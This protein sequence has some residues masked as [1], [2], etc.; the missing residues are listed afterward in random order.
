LAA[1]GTSGGTTPPQN[2]DGGGS[3]LAQDPLGRQCSS[4]SSPTQGCTTGSSTN[5]ERTLIPTPDR[6]EGEIVTA[7]DPLGSGV[8]YAVTIESKVVNEPTSITGTCIAGK[9]I[10]L[11]KFADS[12]TG[13]P[14][15]AEMPGLASIP[16]TDDEW[17]TDPWIGVG[18]D[19]TLYLTFLRNKNMSAGTC[20]PGLDTTDTTVEL[21]SAAAGGQLQPALPTPTSSMYPA[22]SPTI[23]NTTQ[24][25]DRPK[26]AASLTQPGLVYVTAAADQPTTTQGLVLQDFIAAFQPNAATGFYDQKAVLDLGTTAQ[27]LPLLATD[28]LGNLNAIFADTVLSNVPLTDATVRQYAFDPT[29]G[30]IAQRGPDFAPTLASGFSYVGTTDIELNGEM[31]DLAPGPPGIATTT[32]PG[33]TDPIVYVAFGVFNNGFTQIELT[34]ANTRDLTKWTTP[35][36]LPLPPHVDV[37][38]H[39]AVSVDGASNVLD[40]AVLGIEDDNPSGTTSLKN[41]R[42]KTFFYRFDASRRQLMVGPL[43]L[44]Q[45]APAV[46]DLPLRHGFPT[47]ATGPFTG[48]FVGEYIGLATRGLTAVV[49]YPDLNTS[50]VANI[51]LALTQVSTSCNKALTLVDP[52]SL[53]E[54]DCNCGGESTVSMVGCAPGSAT[55]AA[56]ACPSICRHS[57]CG[58]AL[59]CS[60]PVC[61][62][63]S[64]GQRLS[65]QS[66]ALTDGPIT[67]S[68]PARA[69]DFLIKSGASSVATLTIAGQPANTQLAGNVYINAST[70]PPTPG[71]TIEIALLDLHP[72]DVFLAGSVGAFVRNMALAH[73]QRL[74]GTFTDATHFVLNPGAFELITTFQTQPTEGE[75]S[76]PMNIRATNPSSVT[77]VF[78]AAAGAFSL[79]GAAS[80]DAGNSLAIAVQ[81]TVTARPPDSN[82]NGIIDAVDKCPGAKV[83]PDRTPPTFTFVPPAT[84]I[85][86]CTGANIGQAKASDPCGVTITNNAPSKFPLGATI[87]VW[88]AVDGAG[89]VSR[90]SQTVTAVLGDDVSCCPA[91]YHVIRGTSN[92]DVIV[93]TS[94]PDCILGLG[95]QDTIS[96]GGGDDVI[97]GGDGDDVIN[98]EAG[99][100]R[101]YGG[102][103][104][105]TISGGPGNDYIDGGD[106]V[107]HLNGDD[108]DDTIVGG[109]GGDIIHG[110]PGNDIISGGP[111]DDQ[112]HGDDGNDR[113]SGGPGNNML[114]G[115]NGNDVLIGGPGDDKLDGGPGSN[116]FNGGGGHD[117]CID[118]GMTL[119]SCP[120]EDGD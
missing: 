30:T 37:E 45:A 57:S 94:G 8:Q 104:Q 103:G 25:A 82:G 98:G 16:N 35:F 60:L 113:L 92:N 21:W 99:N 117:L 109:Q 14:Q 101:L 48:L 102:S 65:T 34:A 26:L 86:T 43:E 20:F 72:A 118:N 111:D 112:L 75:I 59:Q 24:S 110:G 23:L 89:N 66:C 28:T 69:S 44:T 62:G 61:Q 90:A 42:V 46:A 11:Y 96:G 108:G 31:F 70:S 13:G 7:I 19:G 17:A 91:G 12:S 56:A 32:F 3:G 9:R 97:S 22:P 116:S 33:T 49:G 74:R 51:D 79:S 1:C 18:G 29:A 106:G 55:T 73:R 85:S 36:I 58:Q 84:T 2:C 76:A 47:T 53:W 83:G 54:C 68:P 10:G 39:P 67:G 78:D 15:W 41:L 93:G 100:D 50:G 77:G 40:V 27:L 88:K 95:G 80:D 107:D 4:P 119:L 6:T 81:G 114:F 52:D 105:D 71:A 38:F 115:E 120:A 5:P 64:T 63:G 87:V